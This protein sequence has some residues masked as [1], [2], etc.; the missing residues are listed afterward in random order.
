M[1]SY[2]MIILLAAAAVL[3]KPY[4]LQWSI[5]ARFNTRPIG[6]YEQL[7]ERGVLL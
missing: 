5:D 1:C 3:V 2:P 4:L 7:V 6:Y